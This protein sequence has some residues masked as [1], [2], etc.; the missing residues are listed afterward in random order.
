MK[1]VSLKRQ[2]CGD[3]LHRCGI[4]AIELIDNSEVVSAF[5]VAGEHTEYVAGA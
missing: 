3:P 4:E 1:T 2:L 5:T